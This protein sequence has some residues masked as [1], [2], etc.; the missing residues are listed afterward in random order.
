MNSASVVRYK[1]SIACG[2]NKIGGVANSTAFASALGGSY[3]FGAA[4]AG[5][6]ASPWLWGA[7]M[8]LATATAIWRVRAGKHFY[9]DVAVGFLVG[10][11]LGLGIPL[12]EGVRYLPSATEMAFAG[13]GVAL[14]GLVAVLAPF[15]EDCVTAFGTGS[16][17]VQ[18][19][20]LFS[21][22][23]AGLSMHG[24]F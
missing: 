5:S 8:G 4:N 15:D 2:S 9:S 13:G 7:E 22:D 11:A 21:R 24:N 23:R 12:A 1:N 18:V 19:L 16:L 17:R 3:L 10:S 20:P 6:A 14:G